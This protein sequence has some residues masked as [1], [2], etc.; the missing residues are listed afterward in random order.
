M[1]A[2]TL[3]FDVY[4]TLINTHGVLS[5]LK[6]MIGE[7]A[8]VFSNTWRERQLEYSF[9]RGL[10][11][12]YIPFSDCTKQALDY[13]CLRYGIPLTSDQKN[14][15]L[16]RYKSLPA[17]DD[18]AQGLTQLKAKNY[19]LFAFSNGERHTVDALLKNAG[20]AEYFDGIVSA[21]DIKIFKPNPAVYSHFLRQANSTGAHTWLISSNPFDVTG[22]LSHGMHSAWIKR[23]NDAIFDPWEL[24]P[25][26]TA[27]NL[28]ELTT[29]LA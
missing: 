2:T 19:R 10:M 27:K 4:G 8:Q 13:A 18:V 26:T 15:L 25:T 24:Q 7:N 9:R 28:I 23:T 29:K 14:Q 21:D 17:F 5:L 1:A 22:A 12:N 3:A 11:Q 16:E 20:I 6:D